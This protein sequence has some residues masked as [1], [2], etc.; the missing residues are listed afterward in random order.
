MKPLQNARHERFA[1]AVA[2]GAAANQAY[3]HNYGAAAA[4]TC[5]TNGPKLLRN[6]QVAARVAE[7]RRAVQADELEDCLLTLRA[8]RALLRDMAE[9]LLPTKR[10][11][12]PSGPVETYDRTRAIELDAK[13]AGE[14]AAAQVEVKSDGLLEL[15]KAI[16]AG[17]GE[18]L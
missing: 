11:E 4:S 7:I 18:G 8:K 9:G 10:V 6:A 15:L 12:T 17:K 3:A 5:E 2:A 1:Q 14:F 16:R 13:L